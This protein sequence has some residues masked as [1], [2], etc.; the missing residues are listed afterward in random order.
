V[1][2]PRR[3]L[4]FV[5][6]LLQETDVVGSGWVDEAGRLAVDCL[7]QMAVEKGVLHVQLMYRP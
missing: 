1:P 4:K 5:Q 6:G 3:L 2:C 7:V